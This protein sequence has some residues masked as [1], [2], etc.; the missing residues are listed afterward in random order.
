MSSPIKEVT[1]NGQ[2]VS[3][4]VTVDGDQDRSCGNAKAVFTIP[5]GV[6]LTGPSNSGSSVINVP[7]GFF[8]NSTKTWHIGDLAAGVKWENAFEFT[9]DNISLA[10]VDDNRFLITID[11]S[12]ACTET[13]SVDNSTVLVIEVVDACTQVSLSIGSDTATA[14]SSSDLS[15]G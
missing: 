14:I 8:N 5:N 4:T 3:F 6:R 12:S 1:T 10:N 11:L 15:I 9:V 7:V 2:S 13:N